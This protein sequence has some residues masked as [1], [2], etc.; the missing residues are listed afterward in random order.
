MS[1]YETWAIKIRFLLPETATGLL[2][3]FLSQK[4][5][6]IFFLTGQQFEFA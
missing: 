5:F 6:Q 2:L 3:V 4:Y 1:N